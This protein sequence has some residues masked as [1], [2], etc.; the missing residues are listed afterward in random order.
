V[1]SRTIALT[2]L[3]A[4]VVACGLVPPGDPGARYGVFFPQ[5]ERDFT[6]AALVQGRLEVRDGCLWIAGEGP[7]EVAIWP[8]NYQLRMTDNRLEII[9]ERGR[10]LARDGDMV[11]A[12]GATLT[13]QR[14]KEVSGRV[15][16]ASCRANDRYVIVG[17]LEL[18]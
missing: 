13:E 10:V 3:G 12:N 5:H 17:A 11:R 16:P 7:P 18:R 6:P 1:P 15:A 2:A 14:A 4:I 9:D 8:R